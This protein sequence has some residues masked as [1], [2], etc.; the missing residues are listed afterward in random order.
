MMKQPTC[1]FF[2]FE[3]RVKHPAAALAGYVVGLLNIYGNTC[4]GER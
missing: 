1:Y 2:K 4:T 3:L